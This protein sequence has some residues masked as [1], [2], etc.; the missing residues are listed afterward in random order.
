M[1][2]VSKPKPKAAIG[3]ALLRSMG[4]KAV[5]VEPEVSQYVLIAAPHTSNWD[6]PLMLAISYVFGVDIR[7]MAKH[8]IFRGPAGVFFRGLGGVPVVRHSPKGVVGQMAQLFEEEDPLVLAVA[9]EGT[10]SRTEFWKSGFYR[11]A[12]EANVPVVCAFLDYGRK[13]GGF[14]PAIQLTGDVQ[15]DMDRIRDFY[16]DK[17]GKFPERFGEV[18]LREESKEND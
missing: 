18:R 12:R 15:A 11:I 10:R 14:G 16:S 3:H 6:L 5:G 4:W 7:W 2:S 13:E 17:L 9:T 8:T 1:S